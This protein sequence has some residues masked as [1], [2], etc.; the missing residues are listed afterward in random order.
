[1]E[2]EIV[3]F[4]PYREQGNNLL[5]TLHI[6]IVDLG[7]DIRGVFVSVRNKRWFFSMPTKHTID[8]ETQEKVKYPTVTFTNREKQNELLDLIIEKGK[9]FIILNHF[10]GEK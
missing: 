8:P 7:L 3:G 9:K 5:G 6:N 1:M 10:K 2:I 4:Y